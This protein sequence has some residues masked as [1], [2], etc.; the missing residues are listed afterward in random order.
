VTKIR[1]CR[2]E[3]ALDEEKQEIPGSGG[4][5]QVQTVFGDKRQG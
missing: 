3:R 2:D 5:H 4:P 1:K